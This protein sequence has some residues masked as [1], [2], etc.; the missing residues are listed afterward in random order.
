MTYYFAR[1]SISIDVNDQLSTI[2]SK[3]FENTSFFL[4]QKFFSTIFCDDHFYLLGGLVEFS[5]RVDY[6]SKVVDR[7][8]RWRCTYRLWRHLILYGCYICCSSYVQYQKFV[9]FVVRIT[10]KISKFKCYRKLIPVVSI[11]LRSKVLWRS[12]FC[13]ILVA[14][15]Q[16]NLVSHN[17]NQCEIKKLGKFLITEHLRM[18]SLVLSHWW[19]WRNFLSGQ[20]SF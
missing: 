6:E 14:S 13:I 5:E 8:R 9:E 12:Y 10:R 18:T 3:F 2:F 19:K 11:A 17:F 20:P 16:F 7:P 4:L 1:A 15:I